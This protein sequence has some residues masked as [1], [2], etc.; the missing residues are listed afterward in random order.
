MTPAEKR[1]HA[2]EL[3][4]LNDLLLDAAGPEGAGVETKLDMLCYALA[5]LLRFEG[6]R[7]AAELRDCDEAAPDD[8]DQLE[9]FPDLPPPTPDVTDS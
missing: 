5:G 4:K 9:L 7:L 8:L 6:D 1:A 3:A 2:E